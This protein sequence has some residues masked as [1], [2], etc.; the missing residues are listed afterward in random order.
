MFQTEP[1]PKNDRN[2]FPE[3]LE[4]YGFTECSCFTDHH[5]ACRELYVLRDI[6]VNT[7]RAVLNQVHECAWVSDIYLPLLRVAFDDQV[8]HV[9]IVKMAPEQASQS[10]LAS[11]TERELTSGAKG[12]LS[13]A[14]RGLKVVDVVVALNVD[15]NHK[16]QAIIDDLDLGDP[17]HINQTLY[18]ALQTNIIA[19]SLEAKKVIHDT[20]PLPQLQRWTLAWHERMRKLRESASE[21]NLATLEDEERIRLMDEDK[22]A[23]LIPVPLLTAVGANWDLYFAF[24]DEDLSTTLYGPNKLPS[25]GTLA[26]TY[27]LVACLR[28]IQDWMS[29]KFKD[30]MEAWLAGIKV[31]TAE[32]DELD[33]G[34]GD[35]VQG[36]DNG[37]ASDG[38]AIC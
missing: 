22:K 33:G 17:R 29:T 6:V 1:T 28:L 12:A 14:A 20:D 5:R 10:D 30:A 3:L 37:D 13:D 18:P 24:F 23:V 8:E 11:V 34:K 31:D 32:P 7:Q 19:L 9:A 21:K 38:N 26:E 15:S 16:L 35:S 27:A 36:A 25:T 2:S 4:T